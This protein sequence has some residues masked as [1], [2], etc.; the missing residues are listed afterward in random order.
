MGAVGHGANGTGPLGL[1]PL[2]GAGADACRVNRSAINI[3]MTAV[4]AGALVIALLLVPSEV[5]SLLQQFADL[6]AQA[7]HQI[8]DGYMRLF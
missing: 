7:G 1:L 8:H 4:L 3:R 6:A 5:G 2:R